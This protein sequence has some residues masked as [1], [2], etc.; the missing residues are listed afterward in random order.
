MQEAESQTPVLRRRNDGVLLAIGEDGAETPVK[1]HRVF[2]WTNPDAWFSLRADDEAEVAL[3]HQASDL[4]PDSEAALRA[5]LAEAGFLFRITR[6]VRM[7]EEFEIRAWEVE[8]SQGPRRFQ[9]ARDE[10]PREVPGGGLLVR[11]VAGDLYLV[12][13]PEALDEH[14][15]TL[16]WA[17]VD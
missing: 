7:E 8:T 14:S 13:D 16:L 11:D 3:V 1:V 2:P 10:W 4:D 12:A 9:T 17:L 15:R 5:S 6:I